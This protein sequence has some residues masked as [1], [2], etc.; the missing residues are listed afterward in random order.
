[1]PFSEDELCPKCG[2]CGDCCECYE[3]ETDEE[4]ESGDL[5]ENEDDKE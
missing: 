4:L 1:M 2:G 3:S 5:D